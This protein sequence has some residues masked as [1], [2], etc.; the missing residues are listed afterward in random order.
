[1]N[2]TKNRLLGA[3]VSPKLHALAHMT[4]RAQNKSLSEWLR[5][6]VEENIDPRASSFFLTSTDK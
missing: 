3:Q 2:T 6:L 5:D 4:A 1:M